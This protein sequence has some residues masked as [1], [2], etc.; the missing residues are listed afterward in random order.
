MNDNAPIFD[1]KRITLSIRENLSIG[2]EVTRVTATDNDGEDS[3]FGVVAY[4]LTGAG[5]EDFIIDASSGVLSVG[6]IIDFESR[7]SY[8]V[9]TCLYKYFIK[10]N[11][12]ENKNLVPK[13]I[14]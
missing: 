11:P 12:L 10:N 7:A 13:K 2:T 4:S 3:G 9:S 6:K 1:E 14:V 8:N 5:S